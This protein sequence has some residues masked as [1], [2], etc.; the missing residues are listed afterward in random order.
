MA[1][2]APKTCACSKLWAAVGVTGLAGWLEL[3]L[4]PSLVL[5]FLRKPREGIEATMGI[6]ASKARRR[7]TE[8]SESPRKTTQD[9]VHVDVLHQPN[10]Q[11]PDGVKR[12]PETLATG[13]RSTATALPGPI[14]QLVNGLPKPSEA[15]AYQVRRRCCVRVRVAYA[16]E[17]VQVN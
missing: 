8:L 16:V 5:F 14:E 13:S 2:G 7:G 17:C 15:D 6:P 10:R 1:E 4:F 12:L 11:P 3:S 9:P